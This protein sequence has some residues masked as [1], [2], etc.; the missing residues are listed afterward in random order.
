MLANVL[1]TP[2][3]VFA[4]GG[5]GTPPD[6][7]PDTITTPEET[8]ASGNVLTNDVNSSGVVPFT[9]TTYSQPVPGT[10]GTLVI[11]SNGAYTFTPAPNFSGTA[12]A[13]YMAS[14]TKHEV[15][16][17][18]ITINVTNTQDPPVAGDDTITVVEDTATNVKSAILANG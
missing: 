3:A 7:F 18:Q 14:N 13:T 5:P 16:P 9:V 11:A 8:P 12:T 2:A 17:A 15:G 6:L 1:A 10:A 4:A